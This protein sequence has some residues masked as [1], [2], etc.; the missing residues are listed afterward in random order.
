MENRFFEKP[1]LNSP[2]RYLA[3]H[4]ELDASGNRQS[5]FVGHTY[6]PGANDPATQDDPKGRDRRG[7]LAPLSSV[8]SHPF[9]NQNPAASP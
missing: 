9:D 3:C 5:F 7:G 1:L 6:F 4:W 2:Y 8:I